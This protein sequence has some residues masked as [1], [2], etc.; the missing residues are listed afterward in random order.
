MS[1]YDATA[2][3]NWLSEREGIPEVQWCY[4]PNKEGKF[5]SGMSMPADFLERI[6]YRLPTDEEWMYSCQSGSDTLYSFGNAEELSGTYGWFSQNS[7]HRSHPVGSLL[8]N[9]S[10]MFDMQGNI[11]EWT[12]RIR[13]KDTHAGPVLLGGAFD[14][15]SSVFRSPFEILGSPSDRKHNIGF[16]LARTLPRV[17]L[18]AVSFAEVDKSEKSSE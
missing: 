8:C 10:G 14:F 3:C 18:S 2:Y 7:F 13:S 12:Q 5:E 4:E 15:N 17:P 11:L 1:W 6:G 16:R 9:D